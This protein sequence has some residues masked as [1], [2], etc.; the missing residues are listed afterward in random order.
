[1]TYSQPFPSSTNKKK[2]LKELVSKKLIDTYFDSYFD[3]M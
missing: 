2:D 3:M 1:M